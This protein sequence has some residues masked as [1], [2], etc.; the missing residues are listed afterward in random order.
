MQV[1]RVGYIVTDLPA[2]NKSTGLPDKLAERQAENA[3]GVE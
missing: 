2:P 3:G 1:K